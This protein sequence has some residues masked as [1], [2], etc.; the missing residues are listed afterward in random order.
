[1]IAYKAMYNM[2]VT[3]SVVR[4][5]SIHQSHSQAGLCFYTH[6]IISNEAEPTYWKPLLHFKRLPPQ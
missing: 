6:R 3:K 2:R 1:M 4:P 5:C